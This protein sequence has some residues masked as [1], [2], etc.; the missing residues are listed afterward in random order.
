MSFRR[1]PAAAHDR[2]VSELRARRARERASITK[3][4]P[5]P[6]ERAQEQARQRRQA[7][8]EGLRPPLTACREH[9]AQASAP[10]HGGASPAKSTGW[11][12]VYFFADAKTT[13][14][15]NETTDDK[16]TEPKRRQALAEE[17]RPTPARHRGHTAHVGVP[18]HVGAF[19]APSRR[20]LEMGRTQAGRACTFSP[21]ARRQ[22]QTTRQQTTSTRC[23][24]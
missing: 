6:W 7:F 18:G 15:D 16:T 22:R 24:N 12:G 8:A 5:T 1:G 4:T 19:S 21:T 3:T 2:Y 17:Q 9:T 20:R 10:G 23:A 11:T 14:P 13:E